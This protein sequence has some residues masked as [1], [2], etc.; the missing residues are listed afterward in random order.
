MMIRI[1]GIFFLVFCAFA[2]APVRAQ[3]S[4]LYIQDQA[5]KKAAPL[6]I[7]FSTYQRDIDDLF[8]IALMQTPT[9]NSGINDV[10][11]NLNRKIAENP[12]NAS[13]LISLAHVYRL[14]GQP[15]EANRFYEQ[16]LTLDPDN[17][18][19]NVFSALTSSQVPDYEKALARLDKATD[20]N[21]L[22]LY[23]WMTKGR[24]QM[25]LNKDDEALDSFKHA[26][27]ID[28]E[29][30]QVAFAM[31]LLYQRQGRAE[32]AEAV[33]AAMKEKNPD[34][35]FVQYHLGALALAQADAAKALSYWN[36][37]F[38]A[39]VRDT[40]FL[41]NL[42]VAFLENSEPDKAKKVL[43]HLEFFLP[44]Q[45]DVD[46]MMAES[47]RQMNKLDEATR[48]FKLILAENPRN[49]SALMGLAQVLDQ[50]GQ[51]DER[52]ALLREAAA[53]AQREKI[54]A[55]KARKMQEFREDLFGDPD[56]PA[57]GSG[58]E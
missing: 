23:A 35:L 41:F 31:S 26:L 38:Y 33:L 25:L 39:G 45:S 53:I 15:S 36:K 56:A 16:A 11:L 48:R 1:F 42:S 18:H 20:L 52:D 3:E 29:Q 22:D 34:D 14:L 50:D 2:A 40:Q 6:N 7:D 9:M 4:D 30:K 55:E 21:D 12:G 28:P 19:L 47:Y 27:E 37:V 58:F 24:V 17:F 5:E 43:Q 57:L 46:L 51:A 10:I 13:P 49:M 32:E 54:K 44:G 8:E